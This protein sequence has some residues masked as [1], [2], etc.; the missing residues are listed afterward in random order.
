M[1]SIFI[2]GLATAYPP[3]TVKQDDFEGLLNRLY[4]DRITEPGLQ[5][6]IHFNR[7]TKI[8]ARPII[9]DPS[10]WTKEDAAPP[11]IQELSSI[12]QDVGVA[13]S[14]QACSKAMLEAQVS[15]S[16]I[17]HI[18]AVTCTTQSNP[19][20][21][22]F[23]CQKLSLDPSVQRVLLHGVGCAGGLSAL[24]AA[25]NLAAAASSRGQPARIL[26]IA[27]ELC[28]L[29]LR[30]ELQACL[31]DQELHIAPALFSDAAAAVVVTNGLALDRA[32][33]QRPVY[34]LHQWGSMLV[35]GTA[36]QMSYNMEEHGMIANITKH[37]PKTAVSAILPMLA[38]LHK[39]NSPPTSHLTPS[40]FDWALHPGGASI[41]QGATDNLGLSQDHIRAS[42]AVYENYGNSSS[43][44]VLIVLNGLRKLGPGRDHVVA[45]SFGPGIAIEMFLMQ[46]CREIGVKNGIEEMLR[47]SVGGKREK[48]VSVLRGWVGKVGEKGT[49]KKWAALIE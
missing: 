28:S 16:E 27:C 1:N 36:D 6:L 11:S 23:V 22:L 2:T 39:S 35:P 49:G 33:G 32:S 47:G 38:H 44:T 29:F 46:R 10:T 41:L 9:F 13:L 25:A 7:R 40:E 37:V 34:E 4:P 5:K 21:D 19:G 30:A 26:V 31:Q 12:Y 8:K 43:P 17:T 18:V 15:A 20:Y 42:L 45:A 14:A 24:R 3:H 48:M